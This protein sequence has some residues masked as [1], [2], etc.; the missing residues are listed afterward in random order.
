MVL[1][2]CGS[3]PDWESEGA[4][5]AGN[6]LPEV[7]A[8]RRV[9]V[10][11]PGGS[12]GSLEARGSACVC[13]SESSDSVGEVVWRVVGDWED[14]GGGQDATQLGKTIHSFTFLIAPPRA[15]PILPWVKVNRVILRFTNLDRSE[16]PISA[17][18]PLSHTQALSGFLK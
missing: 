14:G 11:G 6:T 3:L 12:E 15:R 9:K 10:G 5:E 18:C 7:I 2:P 17:L 13:Y 1:K 16:V 8:Q 4:S